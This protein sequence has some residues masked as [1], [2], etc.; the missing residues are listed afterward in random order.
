MKKVD[1]EKLKGTDFQKKVWRVLLQI[2]KGEII[3]YKELA[4]KIGRPRAARAV[5][6]AVGAN[7]FPIKIPCHRVICSDGKIGGYSGK[8]G[9][10]TKR[11][12]LKKEGV[13]M[14]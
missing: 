5:G 11:A 10:K 2:P 13:I 1:I 4:I 7:P 8:G 3:T 9:V 12:L 6:N 14:L